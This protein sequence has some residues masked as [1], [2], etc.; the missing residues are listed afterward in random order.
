MGALE[1]TDDIDQFNKTPRGGYFK[2]L[3]ALDDFSIRKHAI[4]LI[5]T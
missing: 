1:A 2:N 4:S 5:Q 3:I